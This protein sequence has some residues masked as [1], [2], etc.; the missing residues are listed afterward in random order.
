MRISLYQSALCY[1]LVLVWCT[2]FIALLIL[3]HFTVLYICTVQLN[4]QSSVV[5]SFW[6]Q[7]LHGSLL[8][9]LLSLASLLLLSLSHSLSLSLSLSIYLSLFLLLPLLLHTSVIDITSR[10]H[11]RYQ[12]KWLFCNLFGAPLIYSDVPSLSDK[13]LAILSN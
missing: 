2:H 3:P 9:L 1:S 5:W 13:P 6:K 4:M 10:Q 7:S 8:S 12:I 11:S